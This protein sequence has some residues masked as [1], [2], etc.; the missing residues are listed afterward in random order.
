LV[1]AANRIVQES[2]VNVQPLIGSLYDFLSMKHTFKTVMNIIK[3]FG[4]IPVNTCWYICVKW[5]N[6]FLE[7]L[8]FYI[9]I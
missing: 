8:L 9:I 3:I 5:F 1:E 6:Y 7:K 4:G 2:Q